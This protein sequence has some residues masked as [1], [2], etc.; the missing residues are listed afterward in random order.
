[1]VV[2]KKGS[3]EYLQS[4]VPAISARDTASGTTNE[5]ANV[6]LTIPFLP[7]LFL[8]ISLRPSNA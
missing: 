1:M 6:N 8:S 5:L 7:I 2:I 4:G 3:L